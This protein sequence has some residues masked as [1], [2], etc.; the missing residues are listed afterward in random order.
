MASLRAYIGTWVVRTKV[1][2]PLSK[3]RNAAA[4]RQIFEAPAFPDPKGVTYEPGT[5]GGVRGEWVRPKSGP[6]QRMLYLH[7][8]GFIACSPR[9]HRPVTGAL[10]NRGFTIFV[11]DYRLAPEHPF[12][13]AI[14]DVTAVWQAF[15]ADGPACVAGE[16]AGANM[17]LVLIGEA[18]ARGLPM[19]WAAA[20]FSPATDFVSEDGSRRTN[21]WRDAMFDPGALAVIR[22]MYLGS[23]DPAD[24]RI[25]PINADPTGYPPL[26]FHVGE[27]EVLRDDSVRMAEK[28]RAAGVVTELK[29][30]PVVAHAWQFAAHM[31]PEAR[32]SLDEATAF[33][34]AHARRS[35]TAPVGASR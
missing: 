16:S 23:A 28:A 10:A 1:R 18:R 4:F 9:T 11:P 14:E 27:R 3:A 8:G 33:L 5:V 34:M 32:T 25:S 7:G 12:P 6:G 13:A 35:A 26:L 30:F 24:P 31:L 2:G 17:A 20:L 29:L 19:P 21:A 22:T 15:S